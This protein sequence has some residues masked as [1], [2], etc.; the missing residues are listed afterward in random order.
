MVVRWP[1]RIQP[2]VSDALFTQVDLLGSFAKLI[3]Q[4]IP[5]DQ[6]RDS[7][8]EL[9]TLLGSDKIGPEIILEHAKIVAIRKGDWKYIEGKEELYHLGKDPS[10]TQNLTATFPTIKAE[11]EA[12]LTKYKQQPLATE[13]R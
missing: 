8:H 5:A 10:E 9:D 6:A 3:D 13:G 1:T 7:R 2:A 4:D 12:L 11:L